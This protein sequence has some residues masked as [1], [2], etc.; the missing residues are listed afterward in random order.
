M[1]I[2]LS[3]LFFTYKKQKNMP[4]DSVVKLKLC[5]LCKGKE[6]HEVNKVVEC[7]N[8]IQI[9]RLPVWLNKSGM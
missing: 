6:I 2:L 1:Q 3:D 9:K 7:Y 5:E 4:V 8:Y